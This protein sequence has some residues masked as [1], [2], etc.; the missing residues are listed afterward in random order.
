[1]TEHL[2]GIMVESEIKVLLTGPRSMVVYWH[3]DCFLDTPPYRKIVRWMIEMWREKFSV[4]LVNEPEEK[5]DED[6]V[7]HAV[8]FEGQ[9]LDIYWEN[10]LGYISL[11]SHD[12]ATI[13]SAAAA[14]RG[15]VPVL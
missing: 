3:P 4:Q 10:S 9:S 5:K 13:V 15:R 7:V 8:L 14:L 2:T 12:E 6:F 1:M 11:Q